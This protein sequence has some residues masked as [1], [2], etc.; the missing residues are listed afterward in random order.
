MQEK[1]E[2][3]YELHMHEEK[4]SQS[5]EVEKICQRTNYVRPILD[6]RLD[7]F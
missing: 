7:Q 1:L 6:Q 5:F 4:N 3:A 2:F